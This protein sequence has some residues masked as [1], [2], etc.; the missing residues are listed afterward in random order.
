MTNN[1]DFTYSG[2]HAL[3]DAIRAWGGSLAFGVPGESFLAALDGMVARDDFRFITTRHEAGAANMAEAYGKLTGT[4]G[5]AFVTRGPGATHASIGLHTAFQDSTPLILFVGQVA[6]D[7]VEREAFQEIDYRRFFSE[8]SK[9]AAEIPSADRIGEFVGRAFM[10]ATSGRP[11]PVVL[12]LPEDML[13]GPAPRPLVKPHSPIKASPSAKQME[14]V[15]AHLN[16]AKKPVIIVGGSGWTVEAAQ[17]LTHWA[18][19]NHIPLAASFR[20]QDRVNNDSPC[21][22]GD[23]GIG[24]NPKLEARIKGADLILAL[25]PRLGEMTTGGYNRLKPPVVAQTL[26]HVHQ[27]AEEIGRVYQPD[28]GIQAGPVAFVEALCALEIAAQP[29]RAA[30]LTDSRGDYETWNDPAAETGSAGMAVELGKIYSH[31]RAQLPADTIFTNG[32]GNYTSWLHRFW[33]YRSF[34]S[35]L[36]P[37]SGAM[38]YGVPAAIAAKITHPERTVIACAGDGCFMMSVQ[39]LATAAAEGAAVLFL[40]FNNSQLGTIRMHQELHYPGRQSGTALVNPDFVALAQSFGLF[41]ARTSR[42]EQFTEHLD[43][44]LAACR[45]G[46]PALIEILVSQETVAPGKRLDDFKKS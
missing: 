29:G 38:G 8:C 33:R 5:L 27:G 35:Q 30:W 39:E 44:A 15:A 21:Y 20:C 11:G 22:I 14:Q 10:T 41:A 43:L 31:L 9:W 42:T 25:G 32:A 18:E 46:K 1:T 4:P 40:V 37:T 2:G 13:S 16:S 24:I 7:Q 34:P 26:I 19:I 6:S 28:Q 36:A 3:I 17:K 45:A 12:A 23:V